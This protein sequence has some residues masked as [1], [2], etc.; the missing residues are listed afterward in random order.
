MPPSPLFSRALLL[1]LLVSPAALAAEPPAAG[2][3]SGSG[4]VEIKR[5]PD[6]LRV[7]F[8]VM[9]RGKTLKEA[10]QNLKTRREEVRSELAKIGA[11][12]DAVTFGD[13]GLADDGANRRDRV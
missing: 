8:E 1:A 7:Q 4:S 2:T 6:I 5:Q 11:G 9:A 13:P 12:K 3:V 10:L